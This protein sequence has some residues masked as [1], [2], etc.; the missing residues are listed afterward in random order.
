MGN[1]TQEPANALGALLMGL[2]DV[3]QEA[4]VEWMGISDCPGS[5]LASMSLDSNVEKSV[6]RLVDVKAGRTRWVD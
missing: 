3:A 2:S 1:E 5:L 4:K 6:D